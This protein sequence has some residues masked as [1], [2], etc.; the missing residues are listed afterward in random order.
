MLVHANGP[1]QLVSEAGI[2]D[3]LWISRNRVI[4]IH[5]FTWSL[6]ELLLLACQKAS[7]GL[8]GREQS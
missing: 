7:A 1:S 8:D 4:I 2:P 5:D 3:Q 6:R